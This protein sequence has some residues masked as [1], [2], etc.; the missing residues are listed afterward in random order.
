MTYSIELDACTNRVLCMKL[1]RD[2]KNAPQLRKNVQEGRLKCCLLKPNLI[3]D[4]FQVVV[5][6]NKA[7]TAEKL[8][9][10]S[11]YT[12]I[13]FNLSVSK[14]IT[15][16]LQMFGIEDSSNEILVVALKKA[17]DE[18]VNEAFGQVRGEEVDLEEL[19]K[20]CD[21]KS[22]RKAYKVSDEEYKDVAILDSVVSRIAAKDCVL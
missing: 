11:E 2:V 20:F 9:T 6:A 13:L 15:Q 5:A 19:S 1:Y 18:D 7:L 21:V 8:K 10:K 3:V 22:V 12:E 16:S 14:N 17:D 4:A